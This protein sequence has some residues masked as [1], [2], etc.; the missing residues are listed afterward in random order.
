MTKICSGQKI[1]L[2]SKN[3]YGTLSELRSEGLVVGDKRNYDDIEDN[4]VHGYV[5]DV[6]LTENGY[7]ASAIPKT[8]LSNTPTFYVD[9][10]SKMVKVGYDG[11]IADSKSPDYQG[12]NNE[13]FSCQE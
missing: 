5:F 10:K 9:D 8:N 13:Q 12:Q 1:F 3:R 7:F 2:K 11:K 6:R 4:E